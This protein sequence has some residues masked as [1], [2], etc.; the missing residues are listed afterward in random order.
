MDMNQLL[1]AHQIALIGKARTTLKAPRAA[2]G[3]TIALLEDGG[4]D[5]GAGRFVTGEP[6]AEYVAR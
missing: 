4:V 2:Y 6:V 1:H 3:D 5:V